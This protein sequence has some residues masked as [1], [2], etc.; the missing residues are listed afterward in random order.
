MVEFEVVSNLVSSFEQKLFNILHV[1]STEVL[2]CHQGPVRSI[3]IFILVFVCKFNKDKK[4]YIY[5]PINTCNVY[6]FDFSKII[7]LSE[8]IVTFNLLH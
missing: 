8:C 7:D 4:I 1:W 2:I 5:F 3:L 6:V